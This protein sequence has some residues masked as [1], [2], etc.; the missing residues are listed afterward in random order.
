LIEVGGEL[1]AWAPHLVECAPNAVDG[2]IMCTEDRL[3]RRGWVFGEDIVRVTHWVTLPYSTLPT[4]YRV[5]TGPEHR[6]RDRFETWELAH[7]PAPASPGLVTTYWSVIRP[8]AGLSAVGANITVPPIHF[9]VEEDAISLRR[10]LFGQE[11]RAVMCPGPAGPSVELF[12][13][14]PSRLAQRFATV[15]K[16]AVTEGGLELSGCQRVTMG[17][18][19]EREP[20]ASRIPSRSLPLPR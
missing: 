13:R 3:V 14:L 9:R 7:V 10:M 16:R 12:T 8:D 6:C 2:H 11:V 5:A 19:A 18:T 20:V 4:E 15:F 17:I 1:V